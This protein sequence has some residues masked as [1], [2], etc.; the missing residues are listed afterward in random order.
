MCFNVVYS[1]LFEN[2]NKN[3]TLVLGGDMGKRSFVYSALIIVSCGVLSP[4]SAVDLV[5]HDS[6]KD[7]TGPRGA[8][9][10]IKHKYNENRGR[11]W[12]NTGLS[13]LAALLDGYALH[14][15][16][17]NA[18]KKKKLYEA[19]QKG[20]LL[21]SEYAKKVSKMFIDGMDSGI[22]AAFISTIRDAVNPHSYDARM[23]HG[24][25]AAAGLGHFATQIAAAS[26]YQ[27]KHIKRQAALIALRFGLGAMQSFLSHA[28]RDEAKARTLMIAL[29]LVDAVQS[30]YRTKGSAFET[31]AKFGWGAHLVSAFGGVLGRP[32]SMSNDDFDSLNQLPYIDGEEPSRITHEMKKNLALAKK[33]WRFG[34]GFFDRANYEIGVIN[35][36]EKT[37]NDSRRKYFENIGKKSPNTTQFVQEVSHGL[38]TI[39]GLDPQTATFKDMNTRMRHAYRQYHPD[40][41]GNDPQKESVFR[42]LIHGYR[43]KINNK[44]AFE[45]YKQGGDS[46]GMV[47]VD[48]EEHWIAEINRMKN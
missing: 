48:N 45:Q 33:R 10:Y 4:L 21:V 20:S 29:R 24:L 37:F 36:A 27:P 43:K 5:S 19:V 40:K 14:Q 39:L 18:H 9:G 47:V 28:K 23:K 12:T 22:K 44:E 2:C 26:P 32:D 15:Q 42:T 6:G 25:R 7:S 35:K 16:W 34:D 17:R 38:F 31:L 8:F 13:A 46:A 1:L 41:V 30:Y 3:L 11:V